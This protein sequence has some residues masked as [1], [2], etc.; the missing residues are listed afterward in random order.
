MRVA[1]WSITQ[2]DDFANLLISSLV[3]SS[4]FCLLLHEL[5]SLVCSTVQLNLRAINLRIEIPL[6]LEGFVVPCDTT[7]FKQVSLFS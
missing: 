1:R 3:I 2:I 7:G 4:I 5:R 6:L